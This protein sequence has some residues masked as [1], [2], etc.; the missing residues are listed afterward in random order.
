[1]RLQLNLECS[2]N[3]VKQGSIH[4]FNALSWLGEQGV[5]LVR[6]KWSGEVAIVASG[7]GY[8][9]D[10]AKVDAAILAFIA[11]RSF[12]A[13]DFILRKDGVCRLSPQLARVVAMFAA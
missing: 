6:V 8:A 9:A 3:A 2:A 11:N 5:A 1:M 4:P 13:A 7:T 10:P 12:S